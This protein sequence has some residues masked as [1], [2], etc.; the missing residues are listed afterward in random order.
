MRRRF[1]DNHLVIASHNAGKVA[2]IADLLTP[3]AIAIE[4]AADLGLPEPVEDGMTFLENAMLKA[5]ISVWA[6]RHRLTDSSCAGRA[7]ARAQRIRG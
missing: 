2:E 6:R 1:R 7:A 4:S 5:P 3:L